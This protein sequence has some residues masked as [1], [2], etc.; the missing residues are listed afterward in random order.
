MNNYYEEH[1]IAFID[2]LG[3]K[4]HVGK[5][6]TD[7]NHAKVLHDCLTYLNKVKIENYDG[8]YP[9]NDITRKEVSVFSDSI[10]IS[11]PLS[12]PSSV[13]YL[14]LNIIHIQLDLIS[15]G[16]LL[17]G[18]V[19][20]GQLYHKNGVVYGPAMNEAYAIES[21]NAIY[22]RVVVDSKVIIEGVKNAQHSPD[23]EFDYISS[24]MMFDEDKQLVID[25]MCQYQEVNDEET[26]KELLEKIR[27]VIITEIDIQTNPS[28]LQ[29]YI[30]L[31]KYFNETINDF[32]GKYWKNLYI[33]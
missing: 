10:V 9:L 12:N 17:R 5:T 8:D 3:F 29:K 20:V 1:V 31:K 24:L 27:E 6:T 11:Y 23:E 26:Y 13:F 30:W 21:K 19:T 18:G 22:P 25:Y 14:L 15:K 32:V 16:I 2:I 28:V 7:A 4:E 33:D